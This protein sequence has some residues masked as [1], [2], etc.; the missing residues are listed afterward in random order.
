MVLWLHGSMVTWFYGCMVLW[1]HGSMVA[2]FYG[3]M[4]L[5]LHGSMVTWF[6]GSMVTWFYGYMVKL[7]DGWLGGSP[8]MVELL[9][10]GTPLTA[11]LFRCRRIFLQ[12]VFES[13]P[14]IFY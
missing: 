3:Y 2:W 13:I 5:W 7:L 6:Y 12:S 14:C 8:A 11:L 9:I 4:V 1:L 10:V